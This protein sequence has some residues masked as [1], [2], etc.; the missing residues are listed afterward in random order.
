M[1]KVKEIHKDVNKI[2]DKIHR[3]FFITENSSEVCEQ[4]MM[5]ERFAQDVAFEEYS[6]DDIYQVLGKLISAT[7]KLTFEFFETETRYGV[8][9][10][11]FAMLQRKYDV[12]TELIDGKTEKLKVE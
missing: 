4:F 5:L 12:L 10:R 7:W 3:D 11:E 8:L 1:A 2:L 9:G 6:Y